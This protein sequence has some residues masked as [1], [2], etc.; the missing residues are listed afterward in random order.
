MSPLS[1]RQKQE[2]ELVDQGQVYSPAEATELITQLPKGKFDETVEVHIRLGIDPR[3][4][5]QAIRGTISLPAGTGKDVRV[6]VFA[7]GEKAR[8]AEEAGAD[9]VGSDDLVEKVQGGFLDFDTAIA[10]PDQMSKVGKLGKVLG[11]RGM[12]PNPKIGTVTMDIARTVGELKGGKVEYRNDKTGICH[13]GIGKASF[14]AADLLANY[15]TL[16]GEIVRVKPSASKGRY[17]RSITM[18]TTMG[19]GIKV[20]TG[21]TKELSP[22]I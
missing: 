12:M 10:T 17:I 4:A 3:Q 18:T 20:D 14:S 9:V 1:K 7:E 5:D 21:A 19:P 8:E 16:I 22:G 6:A 11:P 15:A 2:R 13:V